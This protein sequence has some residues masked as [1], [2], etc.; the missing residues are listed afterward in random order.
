MFALRCDWL[1]LL[2]TM[3]LVMGVLATQRVNAAVTICPD[4]PDGICYVEHNDSG[5]QTI[6]QQKEGS[7]KVPE[8][9]C[10]CRCHQAVSPA[11]PFATSILVT[12]RAAPNCW[13]VIPT[14]VP[15][16]LATNCLERPPR[17]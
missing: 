3:I 9:H 7:S 10:P 14:A 5:K 12:P 8:K 13:D 2:L 6:G 17:F 15:A 11:V 16:R 4:E 1:Q